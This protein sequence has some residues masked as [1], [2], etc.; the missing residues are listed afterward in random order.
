M[1]MYPHGETKEDVH[2]QLIP[3]R[4]LQDLSM[5]LKL[6]ILARRGGQPL[7]RVHPLNPNTRVQAGTAMPKF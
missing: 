2:L 7:P 5:S 3:L 6:I 4:T 1:A